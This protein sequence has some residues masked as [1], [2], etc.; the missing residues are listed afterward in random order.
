[1]S[2]D[3]PRSLLGLKLLALGVLVVGVVA[4]LATK[5]WMDRL[6]DMDPASAGP[7]G[8]IEIIPGF[9]ALEGTYNEGVTFGLF[10]GHTNPILLFTA[11]ATVALLVWLLATK[12]RSVLLHLGLGLVLA[13]ALGNL[14]DRL[15]WAKVRDFLL[16]YVKDWEWPNFNVADSMIVVGVG[17]IL[18]QELFLGGEQPAKAREGAGERA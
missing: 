15:H 8:R 10:G 7:F 17:L 1:M 2:E 9:F 18:F 13:G 3:G 14:Y 12:R 11:I 4:D 6:L 5:A 16:V